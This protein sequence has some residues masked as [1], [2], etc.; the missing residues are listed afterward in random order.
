MDVNSIKTLISSVGFPI[1]ACIYMAWS[2]EK[3]QKTLNEL[4]NTLTLMNER[5]KDVEI[6]VKAQDEMEEK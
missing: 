3:L 5:I 6:A 1:V 2:N 4:T